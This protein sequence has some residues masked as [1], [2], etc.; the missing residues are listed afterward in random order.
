MITPRS[1]SPAAQK[2]VA[3]RRYLRP[4]KR[5]AED[6]FWDKVNKTD[7]CWLW[8]G[9][10]DSNGYGKVTI[11][12]RR[13]GAHTFSW[14]WANGRFPASGLHLDHLCRVPSCVRPDH[15]E[16]VTPSENARRVPN[17]V[18]VEAARKGVPKRKPRTHC[19]QG[20]Q[21]LAINTRLTWADG[22]T[23]RQCRTCKPV[24]RQ[25]DWARKRRLEGKCSICSQPAIEGAGRCEF[26]RNYILNYL[27]TYR[28]KT[29]RLTV[30][31]PTPS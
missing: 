14:A 4:R 10:R 23:S 8:T 7:T 25:S 16:E 12:Y 28:R 1:L 27:K 2:K 22:K 31:I 19:K 3:N 13:G 29:A 18:R 15:L 17:S 24:S 30:S 9:W 11:D 26:H 6:R 21:L 20:H 5:S